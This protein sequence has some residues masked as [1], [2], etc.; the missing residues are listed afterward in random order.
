MRIGTR[1]ICAN[2]DFPYGVGPQGLTAGAE[3]TVAWYGK[4]THP[5]DGTYMG[6]RLAELQRGEDPAAYCDD[7]PFRA[8]RF[9]PVVGG[10]RL[11]EM[12]VCE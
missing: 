5:I 8:D 6:V 10:E 7:L 1:V 11:K 2:A 3:Y 9:R 4:H 12:E